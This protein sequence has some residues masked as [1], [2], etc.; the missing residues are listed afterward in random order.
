MQAKHTLRRLVQQRPDETR[1]GTAAAAQVR[2]GVPRRK[3]A[4][5]EAAEAHRAGGRTDVHVA[6]GQV[7]VHAP[8]PPVELDEEGQELHE[9]RSENG[10]R[11]DAGLVD[12]V[13][14]RN[15]AARQLVDAHSHMRLPRQQEGVAQRVDFVNGRAVAC[16]RREPHLSQDAIAQQVPVQGLRK[17]PLEDLKKVRGCSRPPWP[18]GTRVSCMYTSVYTAHL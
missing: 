2:A 12:D 10:L 16:E 8:E 4:V 14:Q 3:V 1:E 7:V 11:D 17:V 5:E 13:V 18:S 15:V 9:Q 6:R